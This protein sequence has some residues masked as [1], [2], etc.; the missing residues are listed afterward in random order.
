MAVIVQRTKLCLDFAATLYG[1]NLLFTRWYSGQLPN[2][3]VWWLLQGACLAI[4]AVG[5][6]WLCMRREL[7][8]ITL[9]GA[10]KRQTS[11]INVRNG[12]DDIEMGQLLGANAV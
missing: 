9:V 8:P 5:G 1:F 2:S 11:R 6:E 3:L 12:G 7:A 10:R 4:V